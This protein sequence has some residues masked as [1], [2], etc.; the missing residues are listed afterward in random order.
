MS[1]TPIKTAIVRLEMEEFV[2][3]SSKRGVIVNDLSIKR[4]NDIYNCERIYN[5]MLERN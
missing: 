4:I 1:K 5:K 3:V 2:T